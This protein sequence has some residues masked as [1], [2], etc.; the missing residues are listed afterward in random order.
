[1][2]CVFRKHYNFCVAI[3]E[4]LPPIKEVRKALERAADAD[5]YTLDY[6]Q[7][8]VTPET[9]YYIGVCTTEHPRATDN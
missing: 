6:V 8:K 7:K 5:G 2:D 1:M 9:V 4:T 3:G